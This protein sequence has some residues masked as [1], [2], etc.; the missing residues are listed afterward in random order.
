MVPCPL[1]GPGAQS[2]PHYIECLQPGTVP[3]SLSFMTLTLRQLASHWV[4][5]LLNRDVQPFSTHRLRRYMMSI[6]LIT[7][8]DN[9]GH[10]VTVV[11]ASFLHCEVPLLPF[12]INKRLV[13]RYCEVCVSCFSLYSGPLISESRD[14]SCLPQ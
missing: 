10:W 14:G 3:Q 13:G 1:A 7:T 4:E 8:N 12:V 2:I 5:C 6:C 9:L 11:S